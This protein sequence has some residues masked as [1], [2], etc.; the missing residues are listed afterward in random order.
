M[1]FQ[2]V[3]DQARSELRQ[4]TTGGDEIAWSVS[5]SHTLEAEIALPDPVSDTTEFTFLQVHCTSAPALRINWIETYSKDGI[6][7]SDGIFATLRS[8][9]GS[10]DVDKIYLGQRRSA[11]TSFKIEVNSGKVS[12]W[13][14]GVMVLNEASLSYWV[15]ED[16][17][18]KAG[19]YVNNPKGSDTTYAR[20]K[21][22]EL[23]WP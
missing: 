17:Y 1:S 9:T 13:I 14:E 23:T 12:V 15:G 22:R 5:S 3:G 21:F 10:D 2:I 16:C 4:M 19:A 20:T 8:G 6:T 18:F 7:Y 11:T